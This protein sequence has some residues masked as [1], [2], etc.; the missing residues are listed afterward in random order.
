MSV[1]TTPGITTTTATTS[2]SPASA[3]SPDPVHASRHI[4]HRRPLHSSYHNRGP[5]LRY[6]LGHRYRQARKPGLTYQAGEGPQAR[7]KVPL[8]F[9][10]PSGAA[11]GLAPRPPPVRVV[12]AD[13]GYHGASG[14]CPNQRRSGPRAISAATDWNLDH[15]NRNVMPTPAES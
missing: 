12:L 15:K 8:G 3:S 13:K 14:R 10:N 1:F 11:K 6:S 7:G 5:P 4:G 9:E 2:P